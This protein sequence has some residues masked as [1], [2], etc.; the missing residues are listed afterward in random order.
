MTQIYLSQAWMDLKFLVPLHLV[1]RVSVIW[2]SSAIDYRSVITQVKTAH[3]SK[4][5]HCTKVR[6]HLDFL[7]LTSLPPP[8]NTSF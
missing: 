6:S 8:P 4:A 1:R 3:R 7:P 2:V 5:I